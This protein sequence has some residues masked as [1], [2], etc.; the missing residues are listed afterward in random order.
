MGCTH[1]CDY[2]TLPKFERVPYC[3]HMARL[4]N[5]TP[6]NASLAFY[7][8]VCFWEQTQNCRSRYHGNTAL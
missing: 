6:L 7:C 2:C 3:I 1:R 4:R 5:T 8:S